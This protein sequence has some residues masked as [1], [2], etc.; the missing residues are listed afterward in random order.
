MGL[1]VCIL[2]VASALDLNVSARPVWGVEFELRDFGASLLCFVFWG[3]ALV[4]CLL[5]SCLLWF[6]LF[7][8]LTLVFCVSN[9]I[10]LLCFRVLNFDL[11]Q[12]SKF[13]PVQSPPAFDR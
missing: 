5:G 11:V 9:L 1:G 13:P 10:R 4:F 2:G 8:G 12:R 3:F 6:V 7:W